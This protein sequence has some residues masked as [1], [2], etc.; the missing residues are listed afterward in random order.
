M[1]AMTTDERPEL[2]RRYATGELTWRE[3]SRGLDEQ[4]SFGELLLELARQG[5]ALPTATAPKTPEQQA[6]WEAVLRRAVAAKKEG[7][8]D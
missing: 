3:I 5:L 6:A 2:A 4:V 1:A 7:G 8:D